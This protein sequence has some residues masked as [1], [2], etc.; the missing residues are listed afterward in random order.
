M[1]ASTTIDLTFKDLKFAESVF[2]DYTNPSDWIDLC[3]RFTAQATS[4]NENIITFNIS[5]H[6]KDIE[7]L[8]KS[9]SK[10]FT[11]FRCRDVKVQI[12]L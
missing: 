9:C 4:S 11:I 3:T 6:D 8:I 10:G 1:Q 2:H 7:R 5:G 12:I